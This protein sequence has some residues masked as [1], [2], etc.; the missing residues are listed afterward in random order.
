MKF[1][2]RDVTV[3]AASMAIGAVG[4]APFLAHHDRTRDALGAFVI[5]PGFGGLAALIT[6]LVALK[7][8]RETA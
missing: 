1:R 7:V 6:A 8:A 3:A 4:I 2:V 5:S